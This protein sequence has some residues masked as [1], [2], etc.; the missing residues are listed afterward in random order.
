MV[1]MRRLLLVC[2]GIMLMGAVA[3][4]SCRA[5]DKAQAPVVGQTVKVALLISPPFVT[6]TESGYGGM[7]VELWES[8]ADRLG[9]K[10]EYQVVPKVP[11]LLRA[12][13]T[14]Q[15]DIAVTNLTI[16]RD[17]IRRMDFTQPWFDS[18]LRI[19]VNEQ[20][21]ANLHELFHHLGDAGHLRIYVWLGVIMLLATVVLTLIDRRFDPDF[22]RQWHTGMANSF[23]HVVAVV[24]S[25]R[26]SHKELWGAFGRVLSAVWMVVG[27]AVIAYVTSSVTSVMTTTSLR[28]Q[29]NGIQDLNGKVV[30]TLRSTA[31]EAFVVEAGLTIQP[32]DTLDEAVSALVAKRIAAIVDDAPTLEYYDA[33]HPELPITE[34]GPLFHPSKYGFALPIGSALRF[35]ISQEIVAEHES[36]VLDRMRKTFFGN[37]P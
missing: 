19:M 15:A 11:D 30:G 1:T 37:V 29:I 24:T 13:S 34:V 36:G 35:V 17:R 6:K 8:I 25:G 9:L 28:S 7:A 10:Y 16:T 33:T 12:V 2:L 21:R 20:R 22:P 32:F 4:Q 27:V 3:V 18:G 5:E 26:T 14:G 31:G 23:Y